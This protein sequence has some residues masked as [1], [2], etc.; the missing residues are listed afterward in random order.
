MLGQHVSTPQHSHD[1]QKL[2]AEPAAGDGVS[3]E[4]LTLLLHEPKTPRLHT[5]T[6]FGVLPRV[7]DLDGFA[8]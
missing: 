3:A 7:G 6:E 1:G 4:E 5:L 2:L 8:L